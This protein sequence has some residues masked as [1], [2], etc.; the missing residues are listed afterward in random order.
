MKRMTPYALPVAAIIVAALFILS[1]HS[2]RNRDLRRART[3]FEGRLRTVAA[4]AA[5]GIEEAVLSTSLLYEMYADRLLTTAR[6]MRAPTENPDALEGMLSSMEVVVHVHVHDDGTGTGQFGPVPPDR[7]GPFLAWMKNAADGEPRM[8]GPL[9]ELALICIAHDEPT[10]RSITCQ[11]AAAL[12]ALRREAGIGPM[13]SDLVSLDLRYVALQDEEGILAAAPPG[14]RMS[15]WGDDPVLRRTRQRGSFH[16]RLIETADGPLFEGLQ[17]FEMVDGTTVVLRLS[18]DAEPLISMEAGARRRFQVT[19]SL[20]VALLLLLNGAVFVVRRSR[21]R[22]E[23]MAQELAREQEANRWFALV[24]QMAATVAH[25]VRNP[26]N[27]VRMV[28]SRL[29]KEFFPGGDSGAEYAALLDALEGEASRVNR[30]VTDFLELGKPLRL[31][32]ET[33]D[34]AQALEEAVAP[35]VLRAAAED[36]QVV[37]HLHCAGPVALDRGRFAQILGN[38]LD[39]AIDAILPGQAVSVTARRMEQSL[40][41]EIADEGPG[42]TE[43]EIRETMKPFVSR[44]ATGTGLGFT[45][46]ERLVAAM[47]GHFHLRPGATGGLVA[48]VSLPLVQEEHLP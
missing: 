22:R 45:V 44:K 21:M 20:A 19:T 39:N 12:V 23:R 40:Q 28:A 13:L 46:V 6:W 3:L 10:G 26:L 41:I 30:V 4:L 18:M 35:K 8:D 2:E 37:L 31:Q 27:T 36:K 7:H 5:E 15:A 25:E 47:G 48:Q 33:V 11:D 14:C 34:A 24:G 29:R 9:Q 16:S 42:M 1:A 38:L 32:F 43:E 17:P